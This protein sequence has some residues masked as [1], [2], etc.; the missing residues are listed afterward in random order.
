M[1][2]AAAAY[3][4]SRTEAGEDGIAGERTTSQAQR[5][6]V[7]AFTDPAR[8]TDE[9]EL[10]GQLLTGLDLR[11]TSFT[12]KIAALVRDAG[13]TSAQVEHRGHLLRTEINTSGIVAAAALLELAL[14]F[15]HPVQHEP[16]EARATI[17]RLRDHVRGADYAY[18]YDIAHYMAGLT[19]PA[20][21][22]AW[23]INGE[24]Q[25]RTG[26]H[27]LVRERQEQL[28]GAG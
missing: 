8:A 7:I 14:A 13:S 16:D 18:Y 25:A 15:H 9:I 3:A 23:W 21:S 28:R 11:T 19:L 6:L 10:N 20:A 2:G 24:E 12:S 4:A 26:W 5:A 17:D 1:E 27:A 22:T